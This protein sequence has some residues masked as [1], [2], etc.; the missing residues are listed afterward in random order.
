M[1]GEPDRRTSAAVPPKSRKPIISLTA[2]SNSSSPPQ[3]IHSPSR[4]TRAGR[5]APRYVKS[6]ALEPLRLVGSTSSQQQR[7][8]FPAGQSPNGTATSQ[9]ALLPTLA[10]SANQVTTNHATQSA[11]RSTTRTTGDLEFKL[12]VHNCPP[13]WN[14]LKIYQLLSK[15]GMISRIEIQEPRK[16]DRTNAWVVFCPPPRNLEWSSRGIELAD[17]TG[18]VR[19]HV[20]FKRVEPRPLY[21]QTSLIDPKTTFPERNQNRL[22][23]ATLRCHKGPKYHNHFTL[24]PR[25]SSR[26]VRSNGELAAEVPGH[27]L[28]SSAH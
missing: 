17:S 28:S 21:R 26:A 8:G 7:S 4:H 6:N 22:L 11:I 20:E 15:Y 1:S 3:P 5:D 23:E 14:T 13:D 24:G 2:R 10:R 27:Q 19:F 9:R 18:T 25:N 16:D 12:H